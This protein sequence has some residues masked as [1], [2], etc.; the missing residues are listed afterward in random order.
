MLVVHECSNF[1][2]PKY[3]CN[4]SGWSATRKLSEIKSTKFWI[5]TAV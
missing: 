1:C 5:R 3:F 4:I 2:Y